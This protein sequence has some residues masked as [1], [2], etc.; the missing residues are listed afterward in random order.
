MKGSSASEP[1]YLA[2]RIAILSGELVGDEP[3]RQDEIAKQHGISK[4]PVR[5]ALR[6]LEVEG[7]VEFKPR[8]GAF[9]RTVNDEELLDLL[10]IRVAL[11]TRALELSIPN[12]VQSDFTAAQAILSAYVKSSSQE[13]W[14]YLNQK[15]HRSILEPCGNKRLLSLIDDINTRMSPLLRMR[16]TSVSG[17][18]RPSHEHAEILEACVV[19]N[20]SRGVASLRKHIEESKREVAAQI[21]RDAIA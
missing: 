3:L 15:F 12:M 21:R 20:V 17:I 14:G 11:E 9:V 16:V 19:G 1:V 4:I 13:E 18:E 6:R 10:D 2:L 7:L 8:R 5:E